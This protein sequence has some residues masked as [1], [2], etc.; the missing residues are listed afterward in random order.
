MFIDQLLGYVDSIFTD[1]LSDQTKRG[2]IKYRKTLNKMA[3]QGFPQGALAALRIS[4]NDDRYRYCSC[5]LTFSGRVLENFLF[6]G[7]FINSQ[8]KLSKHLIENSV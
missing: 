3:S 6:G 1:I 2:K 8:S 5:K 7:F 4:G